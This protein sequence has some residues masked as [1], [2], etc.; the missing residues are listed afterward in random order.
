MPILE[1]STT[2]LAEASLTILSPVG[3]LGPDFTVRGKATVRMRTEEFTK[4]R[5]TGKTLVFDTFVTEGFKVTVRVGNTD[6]VA[7]VTP[8]GNKMLWA[9]DVSGATAGSLEIT[10]TLAGTVQESQTKTQ[11]PPS[12][13]DNGISEHTTKNVSVKRTASMTVTIDPTPP[14]LVILLSPSIPEPSPTSLPPGPPYRAIFEGTAADAKGL[15]FVGARFAEAD[16]VAEQ[17]TDNWGSWRAV[18]ALP[19]RDHAHAIQI[20]AEDTAGNRTTHDETVPAD[21]SLPFVGLVKPPTNPFLVLF[22]EGGIT[23]LVEVVA[24]SSHT[25]IRIVKWRLDD[26]PEKDADKAGSLWR[27]KAEIKSPGVHSVRITA[28]DERDKVSPPFELEIRAQIES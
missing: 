27:L 5:G 20:R 8:D 7:T 9:L 3:P 2:K 6:R 16:T 14:E 28:I 12:P 17:L 10:A 15:K 4:V 25:L 23:V 1:I 18:V 11:E 22:Q 21:S 24:G 26:G 13:D 19:D